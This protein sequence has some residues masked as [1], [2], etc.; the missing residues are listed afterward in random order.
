MN[1]SKEIWLK[2]EE[3]QNALIKKFPGNTNPVNLELKLS[4]ENLYKLLKNARDREILVSYPGGSIGFEVHYRNEDGT[5][6]K[7]I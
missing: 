6:E 2:I 4:P 7:V 3:L 5:L 1:N